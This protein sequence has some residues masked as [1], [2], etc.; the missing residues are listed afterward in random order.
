LR[1]EGGWKIVEK[2]VLLLNRAVPLYNVTFII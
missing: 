2:K 1:W